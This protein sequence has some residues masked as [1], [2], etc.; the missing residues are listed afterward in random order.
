MTN[1]K[2][3]TDEG[4][5][6]LRPKDKPWWIYDSLMP[7]LFIQIYPSGTKAWHI[8]YYVNAKPHT[9]KQGN[10]PLMGVK[11]ARDTARKFEEDPQ[12]TLAIG[13][14]GSF[15]EIAEEFF[16]RHVQ[17]KGLRSASDVRRSLDYAIRHLRDRKFLEIGRRDYANLLDKIEDERGPGVADGVYITLHTMTR[18]FEGRS[19][20]YRSPIV[21]S[22]RR[23]H[24]SPTERARSRILT[25]EELRTLWSACDEMGTFGDFTKMLL[26]TGQRRSKVAEMKWAD[27]DLET[28]IWS[29]AVAP[30]EKGSPG[31]LPLPPLAQEIIR[32]QPRLFGVDFIFAGRGGTPISGYGQRKAA[33]DAKLPG[34]ADWCLHDLRR[35][36]RSLMTRAGVNRDHAERTLGHSLSGVEGTYNRHD[37]ASEKGH[38]L[39]LLADLITNILNQPDGANV[40]QLAHRLSVG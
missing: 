11:Q 37:Y 5:K 36:A 12:G 33:L 6:R 30:R 22:M 15:A 34:M 14:V 20:D 25:D 16:R 17:A 9:K 21:P 7:R 3:L 26:L 1:R 13:E 10:F 8:L 28:G 23:D 32:K 18:W 27:V 24:R 19:D 39:Q 38:A 35:T 4:I 29:I 2:R 31:S 40:V